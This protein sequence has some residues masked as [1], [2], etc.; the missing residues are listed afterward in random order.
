MVAL[1]PLK[2]VDGMISLSLSMPTIYATSIQRTMGV[3]WQLECKDCAAT[4]CF[5]LQGQMK[6]ANNA[7]CPQY[8]ASY[9]VHDLIKLECLSAEMR[10][11]DGI[12]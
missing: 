11:I 10:D 6:C 7:G 9:P 1:R 3:A 8:M 2:A 5:V 12:E 4:D